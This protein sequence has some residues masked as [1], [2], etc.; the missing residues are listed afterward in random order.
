[1]TTTMKTGRRI[2]LAAG[3][4]A[5]MGALALPSAARAQN[6][7][8]DARWQGWLG[9]WRPVTATSADSY[10]AWMEQRARDAGAPTL[11]IVPSTSAT[12][13]DFVT[14]A[15]GKVVARETVDAGDSHRARQ[16]DGCDGWEGASWSANARR[17]Y[18]KSEY[19]C[20]GGVTRTS[21]GMLAMSNSGELLDIEAIGS[22]GTKSV[23][24]ARYQSV[25]EPAGFALDSAL[26]PRADAIPVTAARAAAAGA[27]TG[28]DVVDAV[29]HADSLVVEAWIVERGDRFTINAKQLAALADAGVP[30]RITDLLVALAYPKVFALNQPTIALA[31]AAIPATSGRT[32]YVTVPPTYPYGYPGYDYSPFGY[33]PYGYNGYGYGYGGFGYGYLYRPPLV[34]VRP[35]GGGTAR[36]HGRVVNGHGY[37]RDPSPASGASTSTG[38]DASGSASSPSSGSST[39]SSSSSSSGSGETRHA[40][41]R[42]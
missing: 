23:H 8:P 13:V 24:V 41:P 37:T 16:R 6:V 18:L 42:P 11:C 19:D 3:L 36:P 9:C 28:S 22:G 29:A 25:A 40:K 14:V 33:S 34:I 31:P 32:L 2:V 7:R 39:S 10:T 15:D 27:L 20:A 1:M 4:L 21:S 38:R 26:V 30:G 5:A 35:S 12:A 17:V